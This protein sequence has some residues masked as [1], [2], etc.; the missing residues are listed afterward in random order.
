MTHNVINY[1]DFFKVSGCDYLQVVVLRPEYWNILAD[2]FNM[3]L[4]ELCDLDYWEFPS[5]VSVYTS[6]GETYLTKKYHPISLHILLL[7]PLVNKSLLII[8]GNGIYL[9]F[10]K[11]FLVRF[12]ASFLHF[13]VTI[14]F[15]WFWR[16][17][18]RESILLMLDF[19]KAVFLTLFLICFILMILFVFFTV[20][21]M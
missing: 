1:F 6:V 5:A 10:L 3:F 17:I 15:A 9:E 4:K 7:K 20:S 13:S 16:E 12:L 18:F 14:S 2:F 11:E 21:A 8:C 19:L